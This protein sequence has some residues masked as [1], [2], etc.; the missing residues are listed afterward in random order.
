[1]VN[2]R[3][4]VIGDHNITVNLVSNAGNVT[5]NMVS[6][7]MGASGAYLLRFHPLYSDSL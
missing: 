3:S 1:M 7:P 4:T 5:N 2:Q 6:H